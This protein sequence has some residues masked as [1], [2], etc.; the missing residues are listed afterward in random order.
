MA[1][2]VIKWRPLWNAGATFV[3]KLMIPHSVGN[4]A[5][6][7]DYEIWID[8]TT[9]KLCF[10]VGGVVQQIPFASELGT[11][12]LTQEMAED[13]VQAMFTGADMAAGDIT[14]AYTDNGAGAGTLKGNV[15]PA[16]VDAATLGGDTKATI[17]AAAVST[18]LGGAGPAYDTLSELKTLIDAATDATELAAAMANRGR[19]YAG[20]IPNGATPQTV[21]HSLGL[22]NMGDFTAKTFVSATGVREDFEITPIDG[23]SVSI[24]DESGAAIPSGRRIFL[25]GGA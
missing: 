4:P 5:G 13:I 8:E 16:V 10:R 2:R 22:A 11:G 25:V 6:V 19:F 18:V 7:A 14:W 20:A 9:G 21:T 17:I 1:D 12:G 3:K 24:S 23:N 15:K